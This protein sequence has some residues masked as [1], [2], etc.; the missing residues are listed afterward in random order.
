[1]NAFFLLPLLAAAQANELSAKHYAAIVAKSTDELRIYDGWYTALLVRGT[2]IDDSLRVAQEARMAAITGN[3]ATPETPETFQVVLSASTQFMKE[4]S[5]SVDGST[6]WT[7]HLRAG[8]NACLAPQSI[9]ETRK[10]QPIDMA[11]LPHT[12]QWDRLFRLTFSAD[13]CGGLPAS[14]LDFFSARGQGTL[15]WPR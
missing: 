4:L 12:T 7:V 6:P 9:V 5:F 14:A 15:Q 3:P 13:A 10:P 2:L 11:L 1:M 8:E